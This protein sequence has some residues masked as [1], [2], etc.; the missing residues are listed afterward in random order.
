MTDHSLE[1]LD[2]GVSA[3][4]VTSSSR[5][6]ARCLR[7]RHRAVV[8]A[9]LIAVALAVT[10]CGGTGPGPG[11]GQS[12]TTSTTRASAQ[13]DLL[14]FAQCVRSH[15]V[16]DFPDPDSQG[17]FEPSQISGVENSPQLKTASAACKGDLPA[18]ASA[19]T[20]EAE[21]SLLKFAQCMRSHGEPDFPDPGSTTKPPP[22]AIDPTSPQFQRATR[23]CQSLLTPSSSGSGGG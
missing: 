1:R 6:Q 9:G 13:Q 20:P 2:G 19:P 15:G 8:A 21:T 23:A 14:K 3:T 16:P 12:T 7:A 22:G 4:P 17:G 11:V 18:G 5:P 10:A